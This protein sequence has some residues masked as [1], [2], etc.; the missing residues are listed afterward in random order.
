MRRTNEG[1]KK[2]NIKESNCTFH[3]PCAQ[4]KFIQFCAQYHYLLLLYISGEEG[5]ALLHFDTLHVCTPRRFPVICAIANVSCS[6]RTFRTCVAST[7]LYCHISILIFSPRARLPHRT[8]KF[9][10]QKT[11]KR[12]IKKEIQKREILSSI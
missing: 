7:F 11:L 8:S 2:K 1:T 4:H 6:Q 9:N 10:Q 12:A 3:R 5:V